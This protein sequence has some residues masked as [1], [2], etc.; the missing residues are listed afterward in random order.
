[1]RISQ[2]SLNE[3]KVLGSLSWYEINRRYEDAKVSKSYIEGHL[4]GEIKGLCKEL[5]DAVRE[6][7]EMKSELEFIFEDQFYYVE[8]VS[9]QGYRKYTVTSVVTSVE[10]LM[11]RICNSMRQLNKIENPVENA[12]GK[13]IDK[14]KH[15]LVNQVGLDLSSLSPKFE[16]FKKF[17]EIRNLIAHADGN[18]ALLQRN[19]QKSVYELIECEPHLRLVNNEV[20]IESEFTDEAIKKAEELLKEIHR[21]AF[22]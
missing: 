5:D 20:V 9:L 19:K 2:F 17:S 12:S 13:G 4:N 18:V 21:I 14:F 10:V 3:K 7:P 6:N 15:Y 1:M 16:G 8:D 22:N 11:K